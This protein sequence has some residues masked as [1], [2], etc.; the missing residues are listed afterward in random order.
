MRQRG[1]RNPEAAELWER[2]LLAQ[3]GH[4]AMGSDD[5]Y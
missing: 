3:S 2:P 5:R 4:W 1:L